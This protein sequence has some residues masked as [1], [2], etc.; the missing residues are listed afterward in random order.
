MLGVQLL[1][2]VEDVSSEQQRNEQQEQQKQHSLLLPQPLLVGVTTALTLHAPA[3]GSSHADA[4][5]VAAAAGGVPIVHSS[6]SNAGECAVLGVDSTLDARLQAA[7]EAAA[8]AV[9]GSGREAAVAAALR[10]VRAGAAAAAA[11]A[12]GQGYA[13]LGGVQGYAAALRELVALPL[14]VPQLFSRWV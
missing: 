2:Q 13:G 14:T 10:A 7:Q 6:T 3:V 12:G 4:V 5:T 1:F 8:N 11:G 9:Q